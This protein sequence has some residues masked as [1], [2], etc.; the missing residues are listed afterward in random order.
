MLPQLLHRSK[1]DA[2]RFETVD[3]T[4]GWSNAVEH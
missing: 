4:D 1:I 3:A 2:Q